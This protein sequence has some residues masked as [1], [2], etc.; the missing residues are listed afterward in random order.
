MDNLKQLIRDVEGFPIEGVT[1]RDITPLLEDGRVF[2]SVIDEM[3]VLIDD[4][5]PCHF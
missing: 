4:N 2:Q 1:F 5:F 3:I